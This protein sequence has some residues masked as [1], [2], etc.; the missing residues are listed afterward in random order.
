MDNESSN[1]NQSQEDEHEAEPSSSW[2]RPLGPPLGARH[3]L[4]H[5]MSIRLARQHRTLIGMMGRI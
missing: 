3:L 2:D 4:R 1:D 5:A